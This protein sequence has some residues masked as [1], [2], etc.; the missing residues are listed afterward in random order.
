MWSKTGQWRPQDYSLHYTYNNISARPTEEEK[1]NFIDNL[2]NSVLERSNSR[3]NFFDVRAELVDHFV[4]ELGANFYTENAKE[5]KQH[6]LA[7]YEK[8]G[9]SNKVVDIANESIRSTALIPYFKE[10]IAW[11]LSHWHWHITALALLI[12]CAKFSSLDL[13]LPLYLLVIGVFMITVLIRNRQSKKFMED[14]NEKIAILQRINRLQSISTSDLSFLERGVIELPLF[15]LGNCLMPLIMGFS[16]DP[17]GFIYLNFFNLFCL[18]LYGWRLYYKK[19]V[20][21]PKLSGKL[22]QYVSLFLIQPVIT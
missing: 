4:T 8:F 1:I 14:V 10:Y 9:G 6:V 13:Y 12:F 21:Q 5:F 11:F 16:V 3:A 17:I 22:D 7:S 19:H 15:V 20:T 2:I 18:Y